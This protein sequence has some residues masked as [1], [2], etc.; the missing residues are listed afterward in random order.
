[1]KRTLS[2]LFLTFKL[3]KKFNVKA[4]R[5]YVCRNF[6]AFYTTAVKF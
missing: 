2:L 3:I 6:T 4:Q 1:M 5:F